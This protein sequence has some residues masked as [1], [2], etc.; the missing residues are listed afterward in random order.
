MATKNN[1]RTQI[2]QILLKTSLIELMHQKNISQITIKEI[3]EQA[4]LNRS[5][6]YLHYSDQFELFNTIVT[7]MIDKTFE[8]L[9]NVGSDIDTLDYIEA[10]LKF[11]KENSDIFETLLCAQ[12]NS[13]F[14]TQFIGKIL[15]Q[16][17]G[18]LP[19]TCS[20]EVR[21]YVY[22]FLMNGC[23]HIIIDWINSDFNL[24]PATMAKLIYEL[25]DN[26]CMFSSI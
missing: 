1:R 10:F 18:N 4:D 5:T 9:Q 13:R 23:V 12:E 24:S 22:S 21:V 2:T 7:E 14:K 25:C 16:L 26:S 17:K 15:E 6:F 20:D 19:I 8:Y 11:V 3:C